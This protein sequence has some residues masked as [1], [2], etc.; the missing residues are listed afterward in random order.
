M[1]RIDMKRIDDL[2]AENKA[3]IAR[4]ATALE[5]TNR[6]TLQRLDQALLDAT[7]YA[8]AGW[9]AWA[10]EFIE[11]SNRSRLCA[12]RAWAGLRY[13]LATPDWR[14]LMAYEDTWLV[15]YNP[16]D[17]ICSPAKL[18][19]LE[20]LCYVAKFAENAD[21]ASCRI[22]NHYLDRLNSMEY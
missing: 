2:V 6:R 19:R 20:L 7:G 13:A 11:G 17:W 12:D 8:P 4:Q 22:I 5:E 3:G 16:S 14:A 1:K 18:Q 21:L 10:R 9:A 15:T